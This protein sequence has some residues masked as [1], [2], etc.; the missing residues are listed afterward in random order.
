MADKK[1]ETPELE[2]KYHMLLIPKHGDCELIVFDSSKDL[3]K[4][5]TAQ[6]RDKEDGT[7]DGEIFTFYGKQ[8]EFSDPIL[9]YRVNLPLEGE[10]SVSEGSKAKYLGHV[11]SLPAPEVE[12]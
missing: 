1:P 11:P 7:Y 10:L 6:L 3:I 8:V 12:G 5:L 4:R 9:S 2:L